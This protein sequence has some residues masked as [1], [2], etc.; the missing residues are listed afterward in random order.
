MDLWET[1]L[2]TGKGP[3]KNR[4]QEIGKRGTGTANARQHRITLVCGSA[5]YKC[6]RVV[7]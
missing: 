6:D 4:L 7:C 1:A 5:S 3:M 2:V